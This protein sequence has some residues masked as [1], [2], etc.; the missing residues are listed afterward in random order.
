MG[1]ILNSKDNKAPLRLLD[2]RPKENDKS[3]SPDLD[4]SVLAKLAEDVIAWNRP[5]NPSGVESGT[6]PAQV[7]RLDSLRCGLK[8]IRKE[9]S[10]EGELRSIFKE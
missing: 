3:K 9:E 10:K 5:L 2:A 8:I 7:A 6:R 4:A 1:K